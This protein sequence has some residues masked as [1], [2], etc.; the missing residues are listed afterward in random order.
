[1]LL[2]NNSLV[3][4]GSI[5][6]LLR[7]APTQFLTKSFFLSVVTYFFGQSSPTQVVYS[8]TVLR[9]PTT[10]IIFIYNMIKVIVGAPSLTTQIAAILFLN[11]RD[12][13]K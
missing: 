11:Q 6:F 4:L 8:D 9:I 10:N 7:A 2:P 13:A 5:V 3:F 1:M 12:I